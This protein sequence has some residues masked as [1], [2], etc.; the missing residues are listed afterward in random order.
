MANLILGYPN[1]IETTFTDVVFSGGSWE[2][3][4]PLSNLATDDLSEV[5]RSADDAVANTK[6]HVDLGSLRSIRLIAL[7]SHNGSR[8]SLM[9][10]RATQTVKWS[11]G[12]VGANASAGASSFTLQAGGTAIDLDVGDAFTINGYTY[13]SDTNTTISAGGSATVSLKASPSNPG[14]V[15][16]TLQ[17]NI[18]T[19]MVVTCN[20]GLFDGSE[21]ID[22][23]WEDLY[24]VIYPWESLYWG[25]PS[26]WDGK[27]TEEERKQLVFPA[28]HL[29][30]NFELLQYFLFEFDDEGDNE[31]GYFAISKLFITPAWQPTS[32]ASYGAATQYT[33]ETTFEQTISGIK[34]YDVKEPRR[35][36]SFTLEHLTTNEGITQAIDMQRYLGTDKQVFLVWEP[37]DTA[38]MH[39]RSYTATMRQ[40]SPINYS[41]FNRTSVQVEL[42]EVL[43]GKLT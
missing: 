33:T 11:G 6:F 13:E 37:D 1:H 9:R 39:R 36:T 40:L 18:T 15:Y 24:Q 31:D 25:H 7:S 21:A 26:L 12:T 17:T 35:T 23:G 10:I 5:A 28:I 20:H 30:D 29:F 38:L 4:Y 32:N 19:S 3:A 41:Y 27:A 2:S 42:E 22:T 43:G 16:S 34:K 8:S 14:D